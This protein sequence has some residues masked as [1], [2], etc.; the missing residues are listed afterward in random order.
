MAVAAR[1]AGARAG[2]RGRRPG[3]PCRK[4]GPRRRGRRWKRR[5]ALALRAAIIGAGSIWAR[6]A[7]AVASIARSALSAIAS[8]CW[9]SGR[10]RAL[11]SGGRGGAPWAG[12]GRRCARDRR[13]TAEGQG[14][15]AG[16]PGDE[17]PPSG[18]PMSL[19]GNGASSRP[20]RACGVEGLDAVLDEKGHRG[21]CHEGARRGGRAARNGR[22][23]SAGRR[24]ARP[25]REAV[26]GGDVG[27]TR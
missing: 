4:G 11:S 27:V 5:A 24:G 18:T 2:R 22:R 10:Q 20:R 8:A 23:P 9:W 19:R 1:V 7:K 21:G 6:E 16:G 17:E 26:S 3:R 14:G 12:R 13:G 15:G 25:A